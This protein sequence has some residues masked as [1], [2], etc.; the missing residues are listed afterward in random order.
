M[1]GPHPVEDQSAF[2]L[3]LTMNIIDEENFDDEYATLRKR[4][5]IIQLII[6]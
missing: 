1:S 4:R 6:I 5:I 3:T 2:N